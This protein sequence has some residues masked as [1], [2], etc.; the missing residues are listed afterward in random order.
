VDLRGDG[1]NINDKVLQKIIHGA[2]HCLQKLRQNAFDI[3]I[4]EAKS[5]QEVAGLLAPGKDIAQSDMHGLAAVCSRVYCPRS[6]RI[7]GNIWTSMLRQMD[8]AKKA[9]DEAFMGQLTKGVKRDDFREWIVNQKGGTTT[10]ANELFDWLDEDNSGVIY[11]KDYHRAEKVHSVFQIDALTYILRFMLQEDA[12][13]DIHLSDCDFLHLK[14]C[15]IQIKEDHNVFIEDFTIN[16]HFLRTH[17]VAEM[18]EHWNTDEVTLFAEILQLIGK[19]RPPTTIWLKAI[20][21]QERRT[22]ESSVSKKSAQKLAEAVAGL[23]RPGGKPKLKIWFELKPKATRQIMFGSSGFPKEDAAD[24]FFQ[25]LHAGKLPGDTI[26][27]KDSELPKLRHELL[28]SK[29]NALQ[30]TKDP[31]LTAA[32]ESKST[33]QDTQDIRKVLK[34]GGSPEA[35]QPQVPLQDTKETPT[36]GGSPR[37]SEVLP[38]AVSQG[39][40]VQ[41]Q[42]PP[43]PV[44]E[45]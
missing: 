6:I 36:S 38:A 14:S 34:S 27:V 29:Q 22:G 30:E 17:R 44:D 20:D 13:H 19:S 40:A 8:K 11:T 26:Q 1:T 39:P 12:G 10:Q 35:S 16:L 37:A 32:G 3:D 21:K 18:G 33:L 24:A 28:G 4:E 23:C 43:P 31:E 42:F 41:G 2:A 9:A 7:Q 45:S 25:F 5:T 15:N